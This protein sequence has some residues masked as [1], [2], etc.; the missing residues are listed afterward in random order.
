MTNL[1]CTYNVTTTTEPTKIC[2][3]T[4]DFTDILYNG[5]SIGLVEEYAFPSTGEHTLEFVLEDETIVDF[6]EFK[7]CETLISVVIPDNVTGVLGPL[8][9]PKYSLKSI[10]VSEGNTV[11][12]SRNNCN[13]IIE[14][15]TYENGSKVSLILGCENTIIPNEVSVIY[16]YAFA[17]TSLKSITL[18]KNIQIINAEAFKDCSNIDSIWVKAIE[19]PYLRGDNVFL[20][21]KE[22]GTLY[23]PSGSDYS[24]WFGYLNSYNWNYVAYDYPIE[25][26]P[27]KS[28]LPEP[29]PNG[30]VFRYNA[31]VSE[32]GSLTLELCTDISAFKSIIYNGKNIIDDIHINDLNGRA[33]ITVQ[34]EGEHIIEL[35]LKDD[36]HIISNRLFEV[37][38]QLTDVVIGEGITE[39][40]GNAFRIC[41]DLTT[42]TI[43]STLNKFGTYMFDDC[44]KLQTIYLKTTSYSISDYSFYGIATGGTLYYVDGYRPLTLLSSSPYFLGY[45]SWNGIPKNYEPEPDLICTLYVRNTTG[46]TVICGKMTNVSDVFYN[47]SSIMND[48]IVNT[49]GC[50][51]YIFPES[52]KQTLNFVLKDDTVIENR[53]F[54]QCDSLTK[55]VISD[56]VRTISERAF[57][58][59][60]Y[61]AEV[62]IPEGVEIIN[63]NAFYN[64]TDLASI[65][66]PDSVITIGS[67]AFGYCKYAKSLVIG[68]G[69]TSIGT[70]AFRDC[71]NITS[72]T[73]PDSVTEIGASAFYN[74]LRVTTIELGNGV[75][76][77]G[78]NAFKNGSNLNTI[79]CYA[80]TA[81]SITNDTF[82]GAKTGGTLYY[83]SG[84]DY[85]TWLSTEP[86]Y[87]EYYSWN[88]IEMGGDEPDED[89]SYIKVDVDNID[90][91]FNY[92]ASSIDVVYNKTSVNKPIVDVDWITVTEGYSEDI[93]GQ[94]VVTYT[95]EVDELKG[96]SDRTGTI[97]FVGEDSTGKII[98]QSIT[99]KQMATSIAVY[100]FRLE[101][102]Q[103][104]GSNYVQVDY[105]N[106]TTI[107]EPYCSQS[108]VTIQKTQE[109]TA[110]SNGN[111]IKQVMYKITMSP[112]SIPRN[113]NVTFSCTDSNNKVITTNRLMLVQ[114]VEEVEENTDKIVSVFNVTGSSENVVLC[115]SVSSFSDIIIDGKSVGL[116]TTYNLSQGEHTVEYVLKSN[117]IE[118][119][120][121]YKAKYMT[122]ITI[123]ESVTEMGDEVFSNCYGLEK[124]T[125]LSSTPPTVSPETFIYISWDGTLYYPS[126]SDYSL[127][128][129][130]EDYY[131]GQKN[132]NG[133]EI[134]DEP[135]PEIKVVV[136]P[137]V[138]NINVNADGT[139]NSKTIRVGYD[140]I[141]TLYVPL[142]VGDFIDIG[143]GVKLDIIST[144]QAVYEY[145]VTY[146]INK[147]NVERSGSITFLGMGV[148]GERHS[149]IVKVVQKGIGIEEPETPDVP[150]NSADVTYSPIWKD[151]YYTYTENS[152]Y[153]IWQVIDKTEQ[154]VFKGKVYLPPQQDRVNVMI[155]KICQNYFS[156]DVLLTDGSVG[157]AHSY[158][159]F[160]LKDEYGSTLHTYHFVADWSYKPLTLGIKTNPII[161]NIVDGQMLF[162]SAFATDSKTFKYG[163]RYYNGEKD[164]NNIETVADSFITSIIAKSRQKGVNVFYIEDKQ[165]PMLPKCRCQYVLYYKN[166]YGGFD[167][168]PILGKVSKTDE[169]QSYTY[170]NNYDNNTTEF[171]LRSYLNEIR[172]K[173]V[174]STGFLSEAQSARMWE[175]LESTCVYLH[176][177]VDDKIEPVIIKDTSIPYKKKERGRKMLTYEINVESSQTRE[178]F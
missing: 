176:N 8:S 173:Y 24:T 177:V 161:P 126:G 71:Q 152:T 172:T 16:P 131:L 132:W 145:P 76:S 9:V 162:F 6:Y 122:E 133:V 22:G 25:P 1:I 49:D 44:S 29:S 120:S 43:P 39:I 20:N 58:Y 32:I 37:I 11:Y 130:T 94:K 106:P 127:W 90:S 78:S 2:D 80:T 51:T 12:D 140:N 113:I 57:G 148:D 97:T 115:G 46:S 84:S 68:S 21:I 150:E 112:T 4:W 174:L 155:N 168:L 69:V 117:R 178:R 116:T 61:L 151:V 121:F 175:V 96:G 108:W 129:S 149:S 142:V 159:T 75:V 164:Y 52:G 56:T 111:T 157:F 35:V 23:Y 38:Y 28:V 85:S 93:S 42:V 73:I 163:M 15:A 156:D 67:N 74:C 26:E 91:P 31:K 82:F 101:Y 160:R 17:N 98:Q 92:N 146:A 72:I 137:F 114:T 7:D 14:K 88:G 86:D 135:E 18:P 124:M 144:Y 55:V 10:T 105:T 27:E 13:A 153:E 66:I 79:T 3:S 63:E 125:V 118:N 50:G 171:G 136:H 62:T 154:L 48:I 89:D 87:L 54:F 36:I 138:E 147:E 110:I 95:Y 100:K 5:V 83:P 165:Y 158:K 41:R 169:I 123:P 70:S 34:T 166:P 102:P 139:S 45:Y 53:A 81:P 64:C 30:I 40:G 104:G 99:I 33:Y 65:T 103:E 60:L 119:I 107:D 134:G 47:G 167:W 59:C 19:A 143:L 128:L 109:G 77:I 170:T 141:N